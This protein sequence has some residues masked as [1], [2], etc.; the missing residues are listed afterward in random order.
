MVQCTLWMSCLGTIKAMYF[1]NPESFPM[2]KPQGV[3]ASNKYVAV[4]SNRYIHGTPS[5]PCVFLCAASGGDWTIVR[6]ITGGSLRRPRSLRFSKDGSVLC[7][8]DYALAALF[9]AHSG[10]FVG[11]V[12]NCFFCGSEGIADVEEIEGGWVLL[13]SWSRS[14]VLKRVVE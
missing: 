10:D 1:K 6:H 4:S 7:V 3:A 8:A 12:A 2:H 5:S 14:L 9:R 13:Y 11:H